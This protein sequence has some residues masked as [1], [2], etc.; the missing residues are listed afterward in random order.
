MHNSITLRIDTTILSRILLAA[1]LLLQ[2]LTGCI[3][4]PSINTASHTPTAQGIT[5]SRSNTPAAPS[6]DDAL[7]Q[8]PDQATSKYHPGHYIALNDWDGP[9]QMLQAVRPGVTGIHKRYPWKVLEP[10]PGTYDFSGI[11]ADL[12]IAADHGMQLV[13]MIE[14]KSFARNVRMTPPYLWEKYTLPYI[15]GGQVAKRWDPYVLQ[16]MALLTSALGAAFDTHPSLEGIA[17]QESAMGFTP[18]IQRASG[19]TPERYRDALITMLTT[20]KSRF[21]R[22]QVFWY[23]NY[24]EG[25][26]AYIGDVAEAIAPYG[27]VM[28]G[29][30]ILPDSWPLNFHSYPFYTRFKDRMTLFGAVQYDSYKHQHASASATKYWTMQELFAFGRDQLHL[31]YIFWTRKTRSIPEDSY[32]WTNA[33]PVIAAN[34]VFRPN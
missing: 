30:D 34:P 11:E 32:N 8:T 26:Q 6:S 17:F 19:Y 15:D 25:R 10:T 29:P 2:S 28:G 1:A 24:L 16:R 18:E 33:L 20:T 23:M 21:P 13:I 14:D 4:V 27:I 12:T 3:E 7:E 5:A 22:S 31:D 9:T